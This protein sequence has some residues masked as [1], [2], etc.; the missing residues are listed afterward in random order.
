GGAVAST[1][2]SAGILGSVNLFGLPVGTGEFF[3]SLTDTN[4][5]PNPSLC[6]GMHAALGPLE[7]GQMGLAIGCD[8]CVTGTLTALADFIASVSS[9]LASQA[10]QVIY[11]LVER[12]VTNRATPLTGIR[13]RPLTAYFGPPGGPGLLT[14]NE[15]ISVLTALLNLPELAKFLASHPSASSDFGREAVIALNDRVIGL[16]LRV[17]NST[18]P[19]LQF[20][21]SVEPS[22]FGISLTGGNRLVAA[23]M[24]VNKSAIQAD[25]TFSPSYVFGNL[26]FFIMSGG[27]VANVVPALDEATLGFAVGLPTVDEPGLRLLS[28]NAPQFAAT[29]LDRLLANA[30][31]TFGYELSPFG[32]KLAAGQGRIVLPTVENHPENPRRPGGRFQVPVLPARGEI[33]K[34]ALDSNLLAQATWTGKGTDLAKLFPAG[35]AQAGAVRNKELVRDYFPHGGFMGAAKVQFPR[36]LTDAPPFDQLTELFSPLTITNVLDRLNLAQN[37]FTNY[38]LGSR[39][40]GQLSMFVP[41]PNPPAAFWATQQGSKAFI[42]SIS[43]IDFGSLLVKG[44][45][46]YPA[47]QLFM[48]GNVNVQMLGLPLGDG[49]LVADPA[50]GLFRFSAGVANGSWLTN[51]VRAGITGEVRSAEYILQTSSGQL[52]DG[53]TS[54]SL[55]PE[56]RLLLIANALKSASLPGISDSQRQAVIADAIA[57]IT[58]TL[59]KASLSA[60]L[61]LQMPAGLSNIMR[62]NSGAGFFAFSPRFEPGYALPGNTSTILF[63]DP[64]ASNPGPYTLARRNGG[65]VAVGNFTLGFNLGDSNTNRSLI[66]DVPEM[67]LGIAGSASPT[68]FP[69]LNG[70]VRVNQITLPNVYAFN[71]VSAP[72]LRFTG[73]LAF[74]SNPGPGADFLNVKGSMSPIDLGPFLRVVPLNATTPSLL[75]GSLRV[76]KVGT[77]A[78]TTLLLDPALATI[79]MFGTNLQG[80]IFGGINGT[81]FT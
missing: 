31:L 15:Q 63:P 47:D 42:D 73:N 12:A 81:N 6:G 58:D 61:Q 55:Q 76:T 67:S 8:E 78:S 52:P 46:L 80:I 44:T 18:N 75:G 34:A 57:R 17:Y 28:T 53:A 11:P 50:Q 23:S 60:A 43:H 32:F 33:L 70:R 1:T 59:P 74:N 49:E 13:S 19:R 22:I 69:A 71:G 56:A 41:F 66:I 40:I 24:L 5:N 27:S 68:A 3:Y 14:Q 26:P 37:I 77:G 29:Q 9:D 51:F 38:V 25:A 30:A 64:D 35:S 4:G 7:L 2:G 62:F 72:P 48:R 54:A 20:C 16:I 10:S 21:G 45:A 79:P 36:P 65:V 39:Q